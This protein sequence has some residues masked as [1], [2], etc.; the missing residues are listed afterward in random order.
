MKNFIAPSIGGTVIVIDMN[1]RM[2]RAGAM[3]KYNA[4]YHVVDDDGSKFK[5]VD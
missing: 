1:T 5:D 4:C 3:V 2:K